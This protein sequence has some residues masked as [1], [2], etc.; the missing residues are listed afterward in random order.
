MIP[1]L[2]AVVLAVAAS[3]SHPHVPDRAPH[4]VTETRQTAIRPSGTALH[5]LSTWYRYVDGQ[6]AAGPALRAFLGANWRGTVVT[7]TANGHS[8]TA[9]LTDFCQCPGGRVIDL[10]R[11]SFAALAAPSVG[12]I[13]VTVR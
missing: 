7:V 3:L 10:D 5:G 8:V 6:A 2:G 4:A 1:P 9:R 13:R 12:V 11:R